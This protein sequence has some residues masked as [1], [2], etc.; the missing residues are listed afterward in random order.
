MPWDLGPILSP[1]VA[2]TWALA[3]VAAWFVL[4]RFA[5]RRSRA[6]EDSPAR[7]GLRAG[8]RTALFAGILVTILWANRILAGS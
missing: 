1:Q 7:R 8:L 4:S 6:Y 3:L 2:L 5:G